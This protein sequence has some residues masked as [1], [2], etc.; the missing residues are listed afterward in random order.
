MPLVKASVGE[1]LLKLETMILEIFV[2]SPCYELRDLRAAIKAFLEDLGIEPMLSDDKGFPRFQGL[3]PYV[4]C[5]KV[6]DDCPMA[7]GVIERN[8][9][10]KFADWSPYPQY[11]G[12]SPTHAELRHAL[13]GKKRLLLYVHRDTLAVYEQWRKNRE[14]F[15]GIELQNGLSRDTL[16]LISELKRH[17]PAPWIESYEDV[18]SILKSLKKVLVSEIYQSLMEQKKRDEDAA[19]YLLKKIFEL[20]PEL[21]NKVEAGVSSELV[22]AVADLKSQLAGLEA[23]V[24]TEGEASKGV[25]ARLNSDKETLADKIRVKEAEVAAAKVTLFLAAT[26]DAGWLKLIRTRLMDKQPGRVPFHNDQEVALRG[27]HCTNLRD[28]QPKLTCVTW[29]KLP[30]PE[31]GLYRGYKTALIFQGTGFAPGV[32]WATRPKGSGGG[33]AHWQQP[34]TYFG[35]YLEVSVNEDPFESPLSYKNTEFCVR[36]PNGKT[37]E[38]VGFSYPFDMPA[39]KKILADNADAGKKLLATKQFKEAV[40]PLRKAYV[41]SDRINGGSHEL[42]RELHQLHETALD[43]RTLVGLRFKPGTK[44]R[45]VSGANKGKRAIIDR[46]HT[47]CSSPYLLK[48]DGAAEFFAADAEVELDIV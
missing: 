37:S 27:Y 11:A 42:T 24:K 8:Y 14:S 33:A 32:V 9:G 39:L 28:V 22:A 41:F 21:R 4:S 15:E 2:S 46:I 20:S 23:K 44:V 5:L 7:I 36:N 43:Q 16:L 40:E 1:H 29:E 12:L 10:A 26:K 35:D 30:L 25:I 13:A 18:S 34:S 6:L 48:D 47:R 17:D 45:V 38:W 3:K 31:G 19:Q